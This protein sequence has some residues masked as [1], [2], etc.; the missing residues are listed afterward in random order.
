MEK[1]NYNAWKDGEFFSVFNGT[2]NEWTVFQAEFGVVEGPEKPAMDPRAMM[3]PLS[4]RQMFIALADLDIITDEEAIS[5]A[6]TGAIP[7][8]VQPAFDSLPTARKRTAAKITFATFS[9]AFR[10]DNLVELL[11][12][13]SPVPLGPED[14][15]MIWETYSQV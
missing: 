4:R 6:A 12:Q 10:T 7:P 9:Q 5:A 14:L 15:D 2:V 3:T 13:N 1:Q 8:S 11:M